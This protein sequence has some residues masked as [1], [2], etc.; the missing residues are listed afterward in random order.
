MADK[1]WTEKDLIAAVKY[2]PEERDKAMR[3]M[4]EEMGLYFIVKGEVLSG[5]GDEADAKDLFQECIMV[6]YHSI[7]SGAFR[8]ESK[9]STYF[10]TIARRKWWRMNRKK[11]RFSRQLYPEHYF[12]EPQAEEAPDM[13]IIAGEERHALRHVLQRMSARCRELLRLWMHG[14]APDVIAQRMGFSSGRLAKKETYRCRKRLRRFID[15]N[16]GVKGRI[17]PE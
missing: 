10:T 9:I 7:R 16:P 12:S 6:L 3:F 1:K 2:S 17:R 11:S 5:G 8:G 15:E 13:A 14:L 4:V